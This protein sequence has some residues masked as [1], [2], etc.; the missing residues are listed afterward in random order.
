M[1]QTQ[2]SDTINI[3]KLA[4]AL[5]PIIRRVV[6]EELA[7]LLKEN[8]GI[9]NLTQDMP[10]YEDMMEISQRKAQNQIKL[11]SHDEVWSE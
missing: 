2:E 9:F 1:S 7:R 5:E 6:R 10:L 11:H 4:G 8:S 3:N